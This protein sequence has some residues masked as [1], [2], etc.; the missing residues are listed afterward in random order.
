MT[1]KEQIVE[2]LKK[3]QYIYH[4]YNSAGI[5]SISIGDKLV[6]IGKSQMMLYRIAE[7]MIG[8]QRGKQHK[9]QI[10]RLAKQKG[11]EI[12]FDV[13]YY[14]KTG[15]V[16]DE[17]GM[18]EA[19]FINEYIPPLNYQIPCLGNYHSYRVNK[20]AKTIALMEILGKN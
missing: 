17:I 14:A 9:Y 5:Y 15:N 18:K 11:Y 8:I 7:H 10:M 2:Q 6:Y 16:V 3:D 4:K 12:N 1:Y 19:E 13:L 20:T